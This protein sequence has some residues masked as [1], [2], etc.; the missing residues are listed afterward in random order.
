MSASDIIQYML[1]RKDKTQKQAASLLGIKSR[2]GVQ[3]RLKRDSWTFPEL[4]SMAD[5]LGY[6]VQ[7]TIKDKETGAGTTFDVLPDDKL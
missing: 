1:D 6:V 2:Q 4:A 3:A 5:K 7:V